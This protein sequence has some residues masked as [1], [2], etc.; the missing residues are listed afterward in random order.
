MLYQSIIYKIPIST[1]HARGGYSVEFKFFYIISCFY[2][3][4]Q[5][6]FTQLRK[7]VSLYVPGNLSCT[8][9]RIST[10]RGCA[11]PAASMYFV[12]PCRYSQ[13][14]VQAAHHCVLYGRSLGCLFYSVMICCVTEH[15]LKLQLKAC[16]SV[17]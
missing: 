8:W 3:V 2:T 1:A 5:V 15:K 12:F 13:I 7:I 9:F 14:G 16:A 4:K 6:F 10:L 11:Y 17:N